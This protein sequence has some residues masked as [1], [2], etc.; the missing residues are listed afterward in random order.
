MYFS[1][2]FTIKTH[3][4][5]T[6]VLNLTFFRQ[7][8]QI[9]VYLANERKVIYFL[10]EAACCFEIKG[11]GHFKEEE[12]IAMDTKTDL[13]ASHRNILS[14]AAALKKD[15]NTAYGA[16][17]YRKAISKYHR[18]IML[19]KA[20]GL[21]QSAE[22]ELFGAK[23]A[24]KPPQ[25]IIDERDRLKGECYNNLAGISLCLSM[26]LSL[27]VCLSLSLSTHQ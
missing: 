7:I 6:P 15:G 25:E 16:K 17:D 20:V 8:F 14:Q 1:P 23:S 26:S 3:Q 9:S 27:S 21:T 13:W 18:A 5:A 2:C 24:P 22:T 11:L 19:L 4:D 12:K 10:H